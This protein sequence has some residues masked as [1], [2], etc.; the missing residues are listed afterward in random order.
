MKRS[1]DPVV[2]GA[3]L[4][5]LL[6]ALFFTS[7]YTLNRAMAVGGGHWAWSA[8][9]RYLA[10]LPMLAL[11][12]PFQGGMRPVFR[13]IR[14]QPVPWLVWSGV[15]FGVFYVCLS[16]A[17]DSGPSWL[18]AGTFQLT[19]I[20]G[21][22]LSPFI[23]RDERRR[24]PGRALTIG[25][26][27][28]M[29]VL[30]MQFGHFEGSLDR[31][32]WLALGAVVVGAFA[33][34]LGNRK[35]LLHLEQSGESLSATQRVFGMTLMSLPFWVG[36]AA[37]AGIEAGPPSGS[38]VG[39]SSAVA[40]FAGVI[41]TVLFFQATGSVGDNPTALGAVEAMQGAE[42][43]IT[44][45]IGVLLLGESWPQ[46]WSVVGAVLVFGGITA[47]GLVAGRT[48]LN[49]S[50]F[51]RGRSSV[52]WGRAGPDSSPGESRDL[53]W[54]GDRRCAS[55]LARGLNA[56]LENL[57][58]GGS[59]AVRRLWGGRGVLA[60]GRAR[61]G[62]SASRHHHRGAGA[63]AEDSAHPFRPVLA[64]PLLH[65]RAPD[66][67]RVEDVACGRELCPRGPR[68]ERRRGDSRSRGGGRTERSGRADRR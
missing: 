60:R 15:G 5:G 48:S 49:P 18:V 41:A 65:A 63:A 43:L 37:W 67:A 25:C 8:S 3:V 45:F 33:Y 12:L 56:R 47:I 19:V 40:L 54:R 7:S 22:L 26:A 66:E 52:R 50:R 10:T 6:S 34:P 62:T 61:S 36:L 14:A 30:L 39:M 24:L 27:V 16:W 32:A 55:C 1:F 59:A 46:G 42:I 29:G 20:A 58:T 51:R 31:G 28:V 68:S 21:M 17:A 64:R 13:A 57:G 2:I 44:T 23:Y 38:Q 9:L 53:G 11:I 35:L 4:L